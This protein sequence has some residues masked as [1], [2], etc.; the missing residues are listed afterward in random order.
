MFKWGDHY[1]SDGYCPFGRSL[2][3][4][5][6]TFFF[7]PYVSVWISA[8]FYVDDLIGCGLPHRAIADFNYLLTMLEDLHFPVSA[9]KLVQPCEECNC[10][11]VFVNARKATISIPEGKA[12]EI[13]ERCTNVL[14]SKKITKCNLQ[15]LIGSLMYV[16]KCVK[17]TRFFTNRLL[18]GLRQAKSSFIPVTEN[19]KRDVRWFINFIPQFNGTA[20]YRNSPVTKMY[21]IEIDAS[22][23]AVGGVWNNNVYSAEIPTFLQGN[24]GFC[25]VHYEMLNILVMLRLWAK[26]WTHKK[27]VL[28]V[29]IIAVVNVCNSGYTTDNF[30]GARVRNVW[31]ITSEYDID[32]TVRHIAGKRNVVA[33]LLSRWSGSISD[34]KKAGKPC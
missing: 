30:L 9:K 33:D 16:H 25:I 31:L 15:S 27:I 2:I 13:L 24:S 26:Y 32:M 6:L 21:S 23:Q 3:C 29:D 18:N 8:I 11:G 20:T 28:Y 19:I 7:I 1:F 22:L 14:N 5:R 10:L 17:P 34:R 12:K 4:T